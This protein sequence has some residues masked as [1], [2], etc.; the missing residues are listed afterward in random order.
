MASESMKSRP[1][2][3]AQPVGPW[4]PSPKKERPRRWMST[5]TNG[6]SVACR[7]W[8]VARRLVF[9]Y[10]THHDAHVARTVPGVPTVLIEP[11]DGH[12]SAQVVF[13]EGAE[14]RATVDALV[15]VSF[16]APVAFPVVHADM[17]LGARRWWP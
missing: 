7:Y 8:A 10:A 4:R 6:L 17:H 9:S 3:P 5:A 12:L 2:T 11:G 15:P 13:I 14:R 16:G 1:P